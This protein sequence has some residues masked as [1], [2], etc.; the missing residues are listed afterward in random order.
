MVMSKRLLLGSLLLVSAS[1]SS[2]SSTPHVGSESHWLAECSI[3]DDC[4]DDAA[5]I[6]GA[7]TRRCSTDVACAGGVPAACYNPSSPALVQ[8][9]EASDLEPSAG[10]CLR[11]CVESS[12][13]GASQACIGQACVPRLASDP[14][15]SD[16]SALD[17]GA[18]NDPLSPD[19]LDE[20][21]SKDQT[22]DFSEPVAMPTLE[23]GI[24]GGDERIVGTW[25][26]ENCEPAEPPG[27]QPFG[28]TRL[29]LARDAS[30]GVTGT[31]QLDRLVSEPSFPPAEDPDVG[32]PPG[33]DPWVYDEYTW[34]FPA[35]TPLRVLDGQLDGDRLTFTWSP[36]DLWHDWCAMQ[37]SYRWMVGDHAFAFC[38]PQDRTQWTEID[39]GKIVLCSSADFEPL[40]STG[41]SL[42][43]CPCAGDA[44]S[45]RCS[46]AYCRCDDSGCGANQWLSLVQTELSVDGET[47]TGTWS[48]GALDQWSGTLRRV[49]P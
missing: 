48:R 6:C 35:G 8:R 18:S 26:E 22:I 42:I 38:V 7:C 3:G 9:C 33:V 16:G 21:L 46:P 27:T 40:C 1:C 20:L 44:S 36:Y 4:G 45:P 15:S 25:V 47:M 41:G 5:C 28:C 17:G 13:C 32:Y 37:T 30:G 34:N 39:E 10:V 31:V 29:T 14:L 2:K 43:P 49:S 24:T 11:G 19:E 12:D 23:S